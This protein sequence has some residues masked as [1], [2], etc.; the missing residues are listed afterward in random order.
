MPASS[1]RREVVIQDLVPTNPHGASSTG[2]KND[3]HAG[4][5][6]LRHAKPFGNWFTDP[7]TIGDPMVE[8]ALTRWGEKKN[9][10]QQ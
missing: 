7:F 3:L 2:H 9:T 4:H 5:T 6:S 8:D 1:F 10:P